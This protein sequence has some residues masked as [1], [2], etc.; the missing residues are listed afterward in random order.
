M[1]MK[2]TKNIAA[3]ALALAVLSPVAMWPCE[4]RAQSKSAEQ[5]AVSVRLVLRE[6]YGTPEQIDAVVHRLYGATLSPQKAEVARRTF[7]TLAFH[8]AFPMY[9]GK[10]LEPIYRAGVT[11]TAQIK[12]LVQ[13]GVE[14]TFGKGFT[15]ISAE[16][17]EVLLRHVLDMFRALEPSECKRMFL[18]QVSTTEFDAL[19]RRFAAELPLE[20]FKALNEVYVAAMEAELNGY[21]DAR[22]VSTEQAKLADEALNRAADKRIPREV[23]DRVVAD[24]PNASPTDACSFMTSFSESMLDLDEP[25]RSWLLTQFVGNMGAP[26]P[27]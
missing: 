1:N 11:S 26:G 3:L 20:K 2:K 14:H 6:Q 17:Q 25:Y 15:R 23:F 16:Q 4:A 27:K 13:D 12:P 5:I 8:K 7:L 24:V 9:L 18:G 10:L 22:S 21:P 19:E